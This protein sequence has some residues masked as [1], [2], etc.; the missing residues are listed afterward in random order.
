MSLLIWG[1][2]PS[3]VQ[4]HDEEKAERGVLG[5][6]PQSPTPRGALRSFYLS[7]RPVVG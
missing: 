3:F 2:S 5:E 1:I 6:A 4:S 7:V